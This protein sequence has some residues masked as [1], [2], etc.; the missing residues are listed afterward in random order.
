MILQ[1]PSPPI[2]LMPETAQDVAGGGPSAARGELAAAIAEFEV[3]GAELAAAQQR[4]GRLDAVVAEW[5]RHETEQAALVTA[6]RER[7]GAWLAG[8]AGAPRPEPGPATLAAAER[9]EMLHRD[10]AAA[11]LALPE[12]EQSFGRH[13]ARVRALQ[14]RRDAA[15]CAAAVEA[16]RHYAAIYRAALIAALE[17][18]AVLYGLRSA[19]L[20][21]GDQSAAARIGELIVEVKRGAAVRHNPQAGR[22]LLAALASDPKATL[23]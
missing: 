12:A 23:S 8:D 1:S 6:E 18:E 5:T 15:I 11:R 22:Q 13:A 9:R 21:R 19:L 7:L 14:S 4:A 3:A 10:A 20:A 17:H 2:T 16:A